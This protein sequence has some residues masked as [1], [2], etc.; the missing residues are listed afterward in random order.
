MDFQADSA[1]QVYPDGR[2]VRRAGV[3]VTVLTASTAVFVLLLLLVESRWRPL[4]R[5]DTGTATS[6][7]RHAADA[8]DAVAVLEVLTSWVWDPVTLRI[9]LG[10]LALWLLWR[11]AWRVCAWVVA[12][13]G[14]SGPL[15]QGVKQLVGRARPELAEPVS[16]APGLAFPSGHA[17]TAASSFGILLLVLLPLLKRVWRVVLWVLAVVSVVGV[18]FTRVALGVHWVSDV[19]GGWLLGIAVVAGMAVLFDRGRFADGR[20]GRPAREHERGGQGAVTA[21]HVIPAP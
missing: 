15:G 11:G 16:H 1:R 4:M 8:P 19:L 18:G 21:H 5:L 12:T 20:L 7:N 14:V 10:G 9:V 13:A 17:M 6:L 3:A 2:L